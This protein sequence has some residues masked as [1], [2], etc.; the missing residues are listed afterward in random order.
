MVINLDEYWRRGSHW[1]AIFARNPEQVFYFDS[2]GEPP[3]YKIREYLDANFKKITVNN[4]PFQNFV[5][6]VCGD[7]C[8]FFIFCMSYN[9]NFSIFINK[10][11]RKKYPDAFVK[12]F[13]CFLL[14]MYNDE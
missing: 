1:V 2:F 14:N 8:I 6:N 12:C 9:I 7:Y 11:G 3:T 5:S 4:H 13:T 10:L